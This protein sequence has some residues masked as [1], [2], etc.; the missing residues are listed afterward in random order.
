MKIL[1]LAALV[2]GAIAT[3]DDVNTFSNYHEVA[4]ENL[5][6]D[7]FINL[8]NKYLNSTT[9]YSFTVLENGV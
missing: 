8:E 3:E 9:E 5:R 7:W 2:L 4:I 1:L 6:I